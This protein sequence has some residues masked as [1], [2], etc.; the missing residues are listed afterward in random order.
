MA[1]AVSA[2]AEARGLQDSVRRYDSDSGPVSSSPRPRDLSLRLFHSSVSRR[3]SPHQPYRSPGT[4]SLSQPAG[5]AA[6]SVLLAR[7][8][9]V[10]LSLA[11]SSLL[12]TLEDEKAPSRAVAARATALLRAFPNSP[13]TECSVSPSRDEGKKLTHLPPLPSA[14]KGVEERTR[15]DSSYSSASSASLPE[16]REARDNQVPPHNSDGLKK[17]TRFRSHG[18][19]LSRRRSR[20]RTK[21]PVR[22]REGDD[23]CPTGHPHRGQKKHAVSDGRRRLKGERRPSDLVVQ[24]FERKDTRSRNRLA[25]PRRPPLVFRRRHSV[26]RSSRSSFSDHSTIDER[27]QAK[28]EEEPATREDFELAR[29]GH[30]SKNVGSKDRRG[31]QPAS[32]GSDVAT[33]RT[34]RENPVTEEMESFAGQEGLPTSEERTSPPHKPN[35]P[36]FFSLLSPPPS[37]IADE[38]H[39][40]GAKNV[41]SATSRS[42]SADSVAFAPRSPGSSVSASGRSRDSSFQHSTLH[43]SRVSGVASPQLRLRRSSRDASGETLKDEKRSHLGGGNMDNSSLSL[44]SRLGALALSRSHEK[45]LVRSSGGV[46]NEDLDSRLRR[47]VERAGGSQ[48]GSSRRSS[49]VFSP[50]KLSF[51]RGQH[52][53]TA[54]QLG[55][56]KAGGS[57]GEAQHS[58]QDTPPSIEGPSGQS[59]GV[60]GL[61]GLFD[62][63]EVPSK[64]RIAAGWLGASAENLPASA[65]SRVRPGD[66]RQDAATR[67]T[68]RDLHRRSGSDDNGERTMQKIHED[69]RE[70]DEDRADDVFDRQ[71]GQSERGVPR[72]ATGHREGHLMTSSTLSSSLLLSDLAPLPQQDEQGVSMES[73]E[74]VA[75]PAAWSA[76]A[77]ATNKPKGHER[78]SLDVLLPAAR[79]FLSDLSRHRLPEGPY[80]TSQSA[81]DGLAGKS[82]SSQAASQRPASLSFSSDMRPQTVRSAWVHRLSPLEEG[83]SVAESSPSSPS[84]A[85]ARP[86]VGHSPH[87][88][89]SEGVSRSA[90]AVLAPGSGSLESPAALSLP[91]DRGTVAPQFS[92]GASVVSSGLHGSVPE[93]TAVPSAGR[94]LQDRPVGRTSSPRERSPGPLSRARSPAGTAGP[95]PSHTLPE[96][97]ALASSVF[98]PSHSAAPPGATSFT[99]SPGPAESEDD[100][101]APRDAQLQDLMARLQRLQELRNSQGGVLDSAPSSVFSP[102]SQRAR[103]PAT[104][105]LPPVRPGEGPTAGGTTDGAGSDPSPDSRLGRG[106]GRLF[107]G[108]SQDLSGGETG[109]GE[110]LSH[111]APRRLVESRPSQESTSISQNRMENAAD[112]EDGFGHEPEGS[113]VADTS[114]KT[115]F[116]SFYQG[117]TSLLLGPSGG[118]SN[119]SSRSRSSSSGT[120]S[121]ISPVGRDRRG[122]SAFLGSSALRSPSASLEFHRE[123]D[124]T[125][126]ALASS[127]SAGTIS[128]GRSPS[129][130]IVGDQEEEKTRDKKNEQ[131]SSEGSVIGRSKKRVP[132]R[133][134]KVFS[135]FAAR[136]SH[137]RMVKTTVGR[138]EGEDR[139]RQQEEGETFVHRRAEV[140][141]ALVVDEMTDSSEG[142]DTGGKGPGDVRRGPPGEVHASVAG[143]HPNSRRSGAR[144]TP[145]A[146]KGTR[147]EDTSAVRT[148]RRRREGRLRGARRGRGGER[149]EE[150]GE[151]AGEEVLRTWGA[152]GEGK[153][154]ERAS[155]A[156][157]EDLLQEAWKEAAEETRHAL[158]EIHREVKLFSSREEKKENF[159]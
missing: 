111:D 54:G 84:P 62:E 77:S 135:S 158:L 154:D 115:H 25:V 31:G 30:S 9:L 48:T 125:E 110:M 11:A 18:V 121:A 34:A 95:L 119:R 81:V 137:R 103:S 64:R 17:P 71:N 38:Q 104:P 152:R 16:E 72:T 117:R 87:A 141:K 68:H 35:H 40:P 157:S 143:R 107:A 114:P 132:V 123:D 53:E 108:H 50:L 145:L 29:G 131:L 98:S 139:G 133:E 43:R 6:P 140:E 1:R 148:R 73:S 10:S 106:R 56:V 55:R 2:S 3:V 41:I 27:V 61:A 42:S 89:S 83:G 88:P 94:P 116:N 26:R 138:S 13:R 52:S 21:R 142:S 33:E 159:G 144:P 60:S 32:P 91:V 97:T 153:E 136:S 8:P 20:I 112:S 24:S 66:S 51:G 59:S 92:S 14:L 7:S 19:P 147:G 146:G 118:S 101:A 93:E 130:S 28:E 57:G 96:P 127:S 128:A 151:S 49:T 129:T 149:T 85:G 78:D 79:P 37:S 82:A 126:E 134:T 39:S 22:G 150:G 47:L 90:Q 74:L 76:S 120:S 122:R 86:S 70:A 67:W 15:R 155:V 113:Q 69:Q 36:F 65:H 102:R 58:A 99:V 46:D 124:R 80:S 75:P 5:V 105:G 44:G 23:A 100:E 63:E 109:E 156:A 45:D 12:K 4:S